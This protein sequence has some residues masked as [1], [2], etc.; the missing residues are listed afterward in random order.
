MTLADL[1]VTHARV[2]TMDPDRP[3]A[4]AVA[5]AHGRILAVGSVAEIAALAGPD[6]KVI[7]AAG[8]TLLP[9]FFE[10]H[11]HV[12][13]G[14][15]DLTHLHIGHLHGAKAVGDAFR[16]FATANPD[17]PLLMA[18]EA[19]YD[20]LDKP[21]T[22]QDLDAMIADRPIAMMSPD[23]H[24]VWANTAALEAA[25]LLRGAE[26]P[27][28][29][30]VVMGD[31]G[32]ATGELREFEA[33]GP[34]IA[35]AG[36]GRINLGI[37]TGEE[38][39]PRPSAAERAADKALLR[40]GM[41]HCAAHGVT[42]LVNMDG[43]RYTLELLAEMRDE[44]DLPLRVKVPFHF[45]PHMALAALDRASAMAA[46]FDDDWISSGFVKMF[47]DGVIDSK[48]AYML[49]DY[50]DQP[51]HRSEPLF[52]PAHFD[53]IATEI[54]RRGLQI[55]VHAIGDGAVRTVID[56]YQAARTANGPR[57]SR[58]RIEHI[59]LIDPADVS[60]LGALGI[61]A[62]LQPPHAPGAMDFPLQ[63]TLSRIGEARWPDAYRCRSLA[64]AGAAMAFSSDWPVADVSVLRGIAA[65]LTRQPYAGAQDERLSLIDTLHAYTAGGAWAAHRD[66]VTGTIRARLAADLVLL[67]GDIGTTPPA[68]IPDLGVTLT[69]C[70]GR[71]IH[72]HDVSAQ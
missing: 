41:M 3:R 47:M 59:E 48:T 34:L 5:V 40:R 15:A 58:H 54:D 16:D 6:T 13:L 64:K 69:I 23:L 25:G 27:H 62:S 37:A 70:G 42:S 49:H 32:L 51:G 38:P 11:V 60:R 57:D 35:F 43:N 50:P 31:D 9:G 24:T 1:I 12:G 4:E 21:A 39:D 61:T 65:A 44:G 55:A 71:I 30:E 68:Q 53:R 45:K 46:D 72:D 10:G 7:D 26:M 29:H 66:H 33:F 18:Q 28:G 67:G 56:G 20:I 8:R 63:P 36:E 14:G 17:M 52:P 2:L 19:H 22:R